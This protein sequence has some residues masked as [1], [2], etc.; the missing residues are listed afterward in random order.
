MLFSGIKF[1]EEEESPAQL[2]NKVEAKPSAGG[3]SPVKGKG[4]KEA[5]SAVIKP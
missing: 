4:I 2:K 5:L 1:D 3:K